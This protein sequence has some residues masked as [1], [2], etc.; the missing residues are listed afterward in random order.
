MQQILI[1]SIYRRGNQGTEPI[2]NLPEE[3]PGLRKDPHSLV[4]PLQSD[5]EPYPTLRGGLS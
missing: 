4:Q 5:S 2:S 1:L 3:G